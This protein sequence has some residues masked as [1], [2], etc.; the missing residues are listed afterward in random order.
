LKQQQKLQT[1]KGKAIFTYYSKKLQPL[2]RKWERLSYIS[3][4]FEN[5]SQEL[6]NIY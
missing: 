3:Q 4:D 6:D 1:S 2:I 5:V